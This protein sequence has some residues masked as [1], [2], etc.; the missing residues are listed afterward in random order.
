MLT[1]P[2]MMV[3]QAAAVVEVMLG[4]DSG[5]SVQCREG[6]QLSR[7]DAWTAHGG[8]VLL[9]VFGAGGAWLVGKFFLIWASPVFLSLALSALLSLHTSRLRA[10]WQARPKRLFCTPEDGRP[11]P[12]LAR[13]R[14]LRRAY[15]EEA[16]V[17]RRIDQLFKDPAAPYEF[18]A[19]P[20][21]ARR[22]ARR[23]AASAEAALQLE[24][25]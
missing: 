13:S 23:P 3:M 15:A 20:P 25:A 21:Q 17:R 11:P 6:V 9:G 24:M 22:V 18:H 5:W 10:G 16:A 8:H 19:P 12:V 7:R 14:E 1:T 4:R 2:V